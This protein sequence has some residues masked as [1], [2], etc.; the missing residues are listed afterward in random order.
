MFKFCIF[1]HPEYGR[2]SDLWHICAT[3]DVSPAHAP[4]ATE[5][6]RRKDI[7]MLQFI[8]A[9]LGS[10]FFSGLIGFIDVVLWNG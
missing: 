8:T 2:G 5:R 9:V 4:P 3:P 10:G 1:G 6:H 7:I